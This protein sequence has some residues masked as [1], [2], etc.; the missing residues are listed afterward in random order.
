MLFHCANTVAYDLPPS[1][2][3]W[4]YSWQDFSSF[5]P[6]AVKKWIENLEISL[7]FQTKF[8]KS[9]EGS[10]MIQMGDPLSCE[11]VIAHLNNCF[12]FGNKLQL[13]WVFSEEIL[14]HWSVRAGPLYDSDICKC[15]SNQSL[16]K[17][18]FAPSNRSR[19]M[20]DCRLPKDQ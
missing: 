6:S 20:F 10:A 16:V 7:S 17:E 9:K 19:A 15:C 11:R 3:S 1:H 4:E 8:L 18:Y 12:F 14:C 5:Y 2:R 13:G